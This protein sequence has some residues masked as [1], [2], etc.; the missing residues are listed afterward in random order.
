MIL[1]STFYA[2]VDDPAGVTGGYGQVGHDYHW[3][4][5]FLVQLYPHLLLAGGPGSR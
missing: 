3:A 2:Q 1:A 4:L 5:R